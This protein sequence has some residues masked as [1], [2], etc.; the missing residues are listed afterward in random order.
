MVE[1]PCHPRKWEMEAG[2]PELQGLSRLK[3]KLEANLGYKDAK[4]ARAH[5]FDHR[6]ESD[7]ILNLLTRVKN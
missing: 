1:H 6:W 5:G 2:E 4:A 3:S 7:V